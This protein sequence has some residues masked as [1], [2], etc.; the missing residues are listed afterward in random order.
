MRPPDF[1][2]MVQDS[3]WDSALLGICRLADPP[4]M[5]G[6]QNLS[7]QALPPLITNERA[8]QQVVSVWF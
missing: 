5:S 1:F 2:M 7:I 4:Q 6:K 8:R 3:L